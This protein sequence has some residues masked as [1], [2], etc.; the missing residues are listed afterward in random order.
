MYHTIYV[1]S[2][3]IIQTHLNEIDFGYTYK[4]RAEC[5]DYSGF[6][7]L[8]V[9]IKRKL[10]VTIINR[11][12]NVI[13]ASTEHSSPVSNDSDLSSQS[14]LAWTSQSG[15]FSSPYISNSVT[16]S[17]DLYTT[18]S[19]QTP[20]ETTDQRE[21][22]SSTYPT[23][24]GIPTSDIRTTLST[25]RSHYTTPGTVFTPYFS[26]SI[27]PTSD[28]RT[29][30]STHRSHYTTPGTVFTPY[31]SNSIGPTSDR[32]TA[33][34]TLRN[35]QTTSE[36][37]TITPPDESI[38][39]ESTTDERSTLATQRSLGT[40]SEKVIFTS[41]KVS[42]ASFVGSNSLEPT[43]DAGL[44]LSTLTNLEI[45]SETGKFTSDY[46]SNSIK[47]T[48]Y[49]GPTLSTQRRPSTTSERVTITPPNYQNSMEPTT[50]ER[51]ILSTQRSIDT[52]TETVAITLH[53]Y[54]NSVL[55]VTDSETT[56]LT[57]IN[58]D[59]TSLRETSTKATPQSVSKSNKSILTTDRK[60]SFFSNAEQHTTVGWTSYKVSN[61]ASAANNETPSTIKEMTQAVEVDT[62]T[63]TNYVM[64]MTEAQSTTT[65]IKQRNHV[66]IKTQATSGTSTNSLATSTVTNMKI[67][68][69]MGNDRQSYFAE[70]M[71]AVILSMLGLIVAFIVISVAISLYSRCMRQDHNLT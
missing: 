42:P 47:S 43:N 24:S 70:P 59:T 68:T 25:H 49:E 23:N 40:T 65:E 54:S 29:I 13:I 61:N 10:E 11:S 46:Y 2:T 58:I 28:I 22:L 16:P 45:T 35:L 64:T 27:G 20:L 4:L 14:S 12:S 66:T 8:T 57:H 62:I 53:T 44:T 52:A 39:M 6:G 17:S 36:A 71:N 32:R 18:L 38:S 21:T 19:E 7:R 9:H 15:T 69:H 56:P 41:D 60:S 31:S 26:N 51:P 50:N 67:I 5:L 3:T 30:L 34:L 55:P 48:E 33:L 1:S 37:I 63:A